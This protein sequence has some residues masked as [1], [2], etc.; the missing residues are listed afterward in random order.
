LSHGEN[1]FC[2]LKTEEYRI[3]AK[4]KVHCFGEDIAETKVTNLQLPL[5]LSLGEYVGFRNIFV[6]Q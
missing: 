3:T 4:S 1:Y 6:I 2:S 5:G